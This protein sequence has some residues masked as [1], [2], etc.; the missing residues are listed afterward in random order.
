VVRLACIAPGRVSRAIAPRSGC[1]SARNLSIEHSC[2]RSCRLASRTPMRASTGRWGGLRR[3]WRP[4][5]APA[6]APGATREGAFHA[7]LLRSP[8]SLRRRTLADRGYG[9][10][11]PLRPSRIG[12]R[13]ATGPRHLCGV[14]A[15]CR[16]MRPLNVRAA[17]RRRAPTPP[18]SARRPGRAPAAWAPSMPA[19]GTAVRSFPGVP[20]SA[21]G[22]RCKQASGR[23]H[24]LPDADGAGHERPARDDGALPS[25]VLV[26][27]ATR[28]GLLVGGRRQCLPPRR[29]CSSDGPTRGLVAADRS[30]PSLRL[31][32]GAAVTSPT[33]ATAGCMAAWGLPV[34]DRRDGDGGRTCPSSPPIQRTG[35]F[36]GLSS[37]AAWRTLWT[38]AAVDRGPSR[39]GRD[40][41]AARRVT[42]DGGAHLAEPHL[43]AVP[44]GHDVARDAVLERGL[45]QD[46][47]VRCSSRRRAP[48]ARAHRRCFVSRRPTRAR[49]L[50]PAVL[51]TP[52]P[53]CVAA[54]AV[55]SRRP[56]TCLRVGRCLRPAGEPPTAGDCPRHAGVLPACL[57]LPVPSR[58]V[59]LG[60]RGLGRSR[61]RP[62]TAVFVSRRLLRDL[63]AAPAPP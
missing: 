12:S 19:G 33:P 60:G 23:H 9:R 45:C 8:S 16:S 53:A 21:G 2:V 1:A 36:P 57:R 29:C 27:A 46:G 38:G 42:Y 47:R 4:C 52:G 40:D 50:L 58:S 62:P 41:A 13:A 63:A 32:W 28:R 10:P 43:P 6:V 39:P 31:S 17:R 22:W 7:Y 26:D 15:A 35:Q 44:S 55:L 24:P 18:A 25:Q 56:G 48:R 61:C 5:E 54:V 51:C 3:P 11:S 30:P 20:A 59:S 34:R 14:G 49:H 37:V